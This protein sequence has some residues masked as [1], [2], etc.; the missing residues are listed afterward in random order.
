MAQRK[1]ELLGRL[2]QA[3]LLN[4]VPPYYTTNQYVQARRRRCP[5]CLLRA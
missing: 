2:E 5:H 4:D 1:S 3:G